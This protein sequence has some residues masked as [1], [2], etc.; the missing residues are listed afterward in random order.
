MSETFPQLVPLA[1]DSEHFHFPVARIEG[2]ANS[3]ESL[4]RL[5]TAAR[6]SGV[7]LVYWNG[8]SEANLP[9]ELLGRFSGA[10]V[11]RKVTLTRPI[12]SGELPPSASHAIRSWPK[13]SASDS[14]VRLAIASGERSRFR[15]DPL[16]PTAIFESMYEQWIQRSARGEIAD[17]V[18]VAVEPN[19]QQPLGLITVAV[20][21]GVG[22]IGLLAVDGKARGCGLGTALLA[23]SHA[24]M[25]ARGCTGASVVTQGDNEPALRL[26][27]R[28]GYHRCTLTNVYH[29]WPMNN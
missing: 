6:T 11:D 1:W 18:L 27:G 12:G 22:H 25:A 26:Y 19:D 23:A 29:F 14:L 8:P 24:F 16:F 2:N 3:P 28:A 15:V 21:E 4:S 9:D 10:L 17:A 13:G 5:L 20:K 7:R